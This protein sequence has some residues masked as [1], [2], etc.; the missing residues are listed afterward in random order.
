MAQQR[1][2]E[3]I[4]LALAEA[5]MLWH[6]DLSKPFE[7]QIDASKLGVG[8]VLLQD[9][10]SEEGRKHMRPIAFYS[11]QFTDVEKRLLPADQEFYG[12]VFA[13]EHFREY[14]EGSKFIVKT[15]NSPLTALLHNPKLNRRKANAIDKLSRY[16]FT[17]EH[18]SGITN[19]VADCLSRNPYW[20][21]PSDLPIL[22]NVV[23]RNKAHTSS[24][25]P[26][27][28]TSK[29]QAAYQERLA[30]FH[31]PAQVQPEPAVTLPVAPG[32]ES[33]EGFLHPLLGRIMTGYALDKWFADPIN[34]QGLVKSPTGLW[35]KKDNKSQIEHYVSPYFNHRIVIP[36]VFDI[37]KKIIQFN[38][39]PPTAGHRSTEGTIEKV[40]RDFWWPGWTKDIDK[41]CR[42]CPVC[43]KVKYRTQQPYGLLNPLDIPDRKWGSISMDFVTNLPVTKRKN[44]AILIVVDRLTKMSHF[45]PMQ[46]ASSAAVVAQLLQ[47][48][49]FKIHGLPDSVVSDRDPRLVS[50]YMTE[51]W[52][53]WGIQQC[54]STAYRPQTDGQTERVNRTLQEYLRAY[55][56]PHGKDWE[57]VLSCAEYA[58]NDSVS[59]SIGCTP[60]FLNYGCHPRSPWSIRLTGTKVPAAHK[61]VSTMQHNIH[62]AKNMLKRAQD[63]M[64]A[65]Y[66]KHH[67]PFYFSVGDTVLLSSEN[68][69][70][71]GCT[72][73]WP[74]FVGPFKV[75]EAI[76]KD[77]YRLQLPAMWGIHDVFHVSLLKPYFS[78]GT[79]QPPPLP[80]ILQEDSFSISQIVQH[81]YVFKGKRTSLQFLC[82]YTDSTPENR[83]WEHEKDVQKACPQL[84]KSYKQ[85]HNL[86]P[87]QTAT[88]SSLEEGEIRINV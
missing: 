59:T 35:L 78:D 8:A 70:L 37:R 11:K 85:A 84:L 54:L 38:H 21:E 55:V 82:Q 34:T 52:K 77:N 5:A 40:R 36:N 10:S 63:R 24:D 69:K 48:N 83:T 60:F 87:F 57:T 25:L 15:D 74:R 6:P 61:F 39:D 28:D 1:A 65:Q 62:V 14:L 58:L 44:D 33:T 79:Y 29:K 72:K 23:T 41:Y 22:V 49:V 64:K 18:I 75:T 46:L 19:N 3:A 43:Q 81:K 13:L 47:D 50:K 26:T 68:L 45:I 16:D 66:D 73:F 76:P 53:L 20:T 31:A 71:L 4:K 2:F 88:V 7:L 12:L 42:Q 67:Q 32:D 17:I 86:P 80:D 51:V 9:V 56:S 27:S 30:K